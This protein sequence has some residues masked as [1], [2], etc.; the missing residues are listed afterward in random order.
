MV[1]VESRGCGAMRLACDD[2]DALKEPWKFL[3]L[4]LGLARLL[5]NSEF[6]VARLC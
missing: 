4:W 1:V 3:L 2:V 5:V 6:V